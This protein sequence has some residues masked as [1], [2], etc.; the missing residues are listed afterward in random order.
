MTNDEIELKRISYAELKDSTFDL[1]G[2]DYGIVSGYFNSTTRVALLSNPNLTNYSNTVLGI[3]YIN[4]Q[5]V[6]RHMLMPTKICIN[7][8]ITTLQTGGGHEVVDSYRGKGLGTK[9]VRE[10]IFNSEYPIYI[11]QYYSTAAVSILKK[12]GMTF[13]EI[14]QFIKICKAEPILREKGIKHP[15]I[16]AKII[17][18]I[19]MI[20]DFG[21]TMKL[22]KLNK[23]YKITKERIVPE[24][25]SELVASEDHKYY[26]VHD[27]DW[28]QWN[29]DNKFTSNPKDKNSFYSIYDNSQKPVGFFFTKER[30]EEHLEGNYWNTLRGTI[31]E[32]GIDRKSDL[33]E[34][35]I[36]LLALK[37]FSS[38]V[39]RI[40]TVISDV[41]DLRSIKKLRFIRHGNFQMSIRINK[42]FHKDFPEDILEQ[43]NW[44]IRYGGCNTALV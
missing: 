6:G 7:N 16:I 26:E 40:I 10:C 19:L 34:V 29:L 11:G 32:W 27:R 39:D 14:P 3:I 1:V 15:T 4:G 43:E 23:K 21:N 8:E 5:I 38:D 44:R 24:W 42:D 18:V 25:V 30:F 36:N 41:Q 13:F 20:L 31:L 22:K 12:L 37:T 9:L 2:D 33:S 35:D 17:D 28:F